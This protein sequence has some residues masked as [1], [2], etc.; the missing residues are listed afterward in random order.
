MRATSWVPGPSASCFACKQ[1]TCV[2]RCDGIPGNG[3]NSSG[4]RCVEVGASDK[5]PCLRASDMY[6]QLRQHSCWPNFSKVAGVLGVRCKLLC[7]QAS[8]KHA[9]LSPSTITVSH[10]QSMPAV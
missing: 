10:S 5:L 6:G 4:L 7:L 3:K 8:D 2:A 9:L 1:A